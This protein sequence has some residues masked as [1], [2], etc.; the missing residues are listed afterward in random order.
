MTKRLLIAAFTLLSFSLPSLAAP[1]NLDS[2][3]AGEVPAAEA[4]VPAAP[5]AAAQ[6]EW[7]VMVYATTKDVL[8]Y[9]MA[10]QLI[11]LV[12]VGSTDK[13]NVVLETSFPVEGADGTVSTPTVR[14]ALGAPWS[15]QQLDQTLASG[16][17]ESSKQLK[18]SFLGAFEPYTVKREASADTGD[19]RRAADFT[20]WAKANY[21]AKRYLFLVFGH[22]N[23]IFDMKKKH[24]KGTL[25]DTDTQNYVTLPEM[26]LLM[27]QTGKVD[28]FVM[29]SC[30]MQMAEV[31]WQVKD[32]TD[33]V[34]GSGELMWAVSYDLNAMLKSMNANPGASAAEIGRELS[35]GYL[36]RARAKGYKGAHSS[37]ILT[38][39]L[40]GFAGKLDL[41]A[42]SQLALRDEKAVTAARKRVVRYDMFGITQSTIPAIANY[43]SQS[44][45][46]YDFVRLVTENTPQDTPERLLAR[47]RGLDLMDYIEKELVYSHSNYGTSHIQY[48]FARARGLA[49]Y[50]P[51]GGHF[52]GTGTLD[53]FES[54][55]E[56]KYGDLPFARETRWGAFV[57]W[58]NKRN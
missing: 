11:D 22:G 37:V 38:G 39:K 58:I 40:P 13:V 19:W 14:M 46:L 15:Q 36:A 25:M 45:D 54:N 55:V 2:I 50:V 53:D 27:E 8:K 18:E 44:G 24:D 31:T 41:W 56:T 29:L 51:P 28:A 16:F 4:P 17:N 26:R 7:T 35:E 21:P 1:F 48:E 47:Q 3:R 57:N 34:V 43:F 33:V 12:Q 49:V 42:D 10:D 23:G 20:R 52:F 9:F 6:K 5:P 32:Y 30:I